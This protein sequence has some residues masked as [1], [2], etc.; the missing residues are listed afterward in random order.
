M[1]FRGYL[2]SVVLWILFGI[3]CCMV[4][5]PIALSIF[6]IATVYCGFGWMID[7]AALVHGRVNEE[8]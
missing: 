2:E 3:A 4:V 5:A 8:L 1:P 7:V 6:A